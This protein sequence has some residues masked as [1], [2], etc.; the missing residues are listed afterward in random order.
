M[1]RALVEFAVCLLVL[2]A[3]FGVKH[4]ACLAAGRG[5]EPLQGVPIVSNNTRE[6]C[7]RE[8]HVKSTTISIT[9]PR[10]RCI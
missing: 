4:A 8:M 9:C 10:S 6:P 2:G 3:T 7:Y 5:E 1:H